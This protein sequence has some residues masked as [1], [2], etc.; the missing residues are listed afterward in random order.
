MVSNLIHSSALSLS[1]SLSNSHNP[2]LYSRT[3]Y[4]IL[5]S[6]TID[7][8]KPANEQLQTVAISY[9]DDD[10]EEEGEEEEEEGEEEEEEEEEEED[11]D[12]EEARGG[13]GGG[14][15]GGGDD[16]DS[17]QKKRI[18]KM[19]LTTT[20]FVKRDDEICQVVVVAR[21]NDRRIVR[22]EKEFTTESLFVNDA[23]SG[24]LTIDEGGEFSSKFD[25]NVQYY[26][27]DCEPATLQLKIAD[28]FNITE[29]QDVLLPEHAICRIPCG[30]KFV[31]KNNSATKKAKLYYHV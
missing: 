20:L 18:E 26:V 25:A 7:A 11:E 17:N 19:L 21:K 24:M 9:D 10:Y 5:A 27:V 28:P 8:N 16:D 12:E 6:Q 23:F 3:S 29:Y 14:G 4:L 13:G 1:L 31:F 30:N 15:G 22:T 2:N